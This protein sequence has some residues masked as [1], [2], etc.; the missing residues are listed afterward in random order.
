MTVIFSV[1][2]SQLSNGSMK[3]LWDMR[4]ILPIEGSDASLEKIMRHGQST[5]FDPTYCFKIHSSVS[6]K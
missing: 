6:K 4:H 5:C 2:I 1:G 3:K